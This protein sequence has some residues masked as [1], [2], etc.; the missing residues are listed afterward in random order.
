MTGITVGFKPTVVKEDFCSAGGTARE[1]IVSAIKSAVSSALPR[2]FR[3]STGF[4]AVMP[5]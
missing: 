1:S 4:A 2:R 5:I 3:R